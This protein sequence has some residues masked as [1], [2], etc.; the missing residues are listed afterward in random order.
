[1]RWAENKFVIKDLIW[2]KLKVSYMWFGLIFYSLL[3]I[4]NWHKL[5]W[6]PTYQKCKLWIKRFLFCPHTHW[7]IIVTWPTHVARI[8]KGVFDPPKSRPLYCMGHS[9][10]LRCT[11]MCC[12]NGLLFHKK[13]L[14][15]GPL[16]YQ[17]I[18]KHVSVFSKN[19]EKWTYIWRNIPKFGYFFAKWQVFWGS[20]S[21]RPCKPNLNNPW[22]C[23]PNCWPILR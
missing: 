22:D 18:T 17:N 15:I 23:T 16:F 1:M 12:S 19:L 4:R 5:L 14:N 10:I 9:H 21:A 8:F 20:S 7:V 6:E 13:S 2:N 3:E 11:G